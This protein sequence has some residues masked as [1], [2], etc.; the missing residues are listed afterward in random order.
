MIAF[1]RKTTTAPAGLERWLT[2]RPRLV[3][4]AVA[5]AATATAVTS[6]GELELLRASEMITDV[7][8]WDIIIRCGAAWIAWA[9]VSPLLLGLAFLIARSAS[10]WLVAAL[11]HLPLAFGVG[12]AFLAGEIA[13]QEALQGPAKTAFFHRLLERRETSRE[14]DPTSEVRRDRDPGEDEQ[15]RRRDESGDPEGEILP[16]TPSLG[17]AEH[18]A[19]PAPE[20]EGES[21]PA[22]YDEE[23]GGPGERSRNDGREMRR[24]PDDRDEI[25]ELRAQ[26]QVDRDTARQLRRFG[27]YSTANVATGDFAADFERRWL[28][29]VPRYG[30]IYLALVLIGLGSRAFLIGRQREREAVDLELRAER[31]EAEL[32][33]ARLTALSGQLHP[34]FLF[35]ALH[36]VGG[37]IRSAEPG[38]AL[39]A[40]AQIGDLLRTSL[41]AGGEQFIPMGREFELLRRYLDVEALRLG[42]KLRVEF[43][44]D[45]AVEECEV[46]AFITQ[47]LVENAVKH[48][49][50]QSPQ[51]GRVAIT[52]SAVEGEILEITIE[53]DGP[54][55]P[56]AP[57]EGIGLTH[58][59]AR[60][61]TLF[62]GAGSLRLEK[63]S[64][65]EGARA[66]L[67]LPL[68]DV[69]FGTEAR[70]R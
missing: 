42:D 1:V 46:P 56:E 4:V 32:T 13:V 11:C 23:D 64:E 39:T 12:S 6:M 37:L 31:L 60:L 36:S 10:H 45:P 55:P 59:R 14:D 3:L 47:P 65:V 21:R 44:V 5:T 51:G 53:N 66:V 49:V 25:R 62:D 50:A 43:T 67:R 58:V 28:L 70:D 48:G 52:A 26:L 30:I 17:T 69:A 16:R 34:H 35:N 7:A 41:D 54:A 29:R 19:E 61:E 9:L 8:E 22:A 68:D 57:D 20:P 63:L 2:S 18:A 15:D 38:R 24:S 33:E 27:R 40:L